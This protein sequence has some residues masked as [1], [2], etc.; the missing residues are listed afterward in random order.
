MGR[1]VVKDYQLRYAAGT[2]WL[3]HM[4]QPGI[5]YQPPVMINETGAFIWKKLESG[6]TLENIAEDIS[7]TYRVLQ[8]DALE[9]V[10]LFCNK[11]LEHGIRIGE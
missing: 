7:K 11:L 10:Q 9:D 4:N 6:W 8:K 5:P 2:Y 3:L 1:E